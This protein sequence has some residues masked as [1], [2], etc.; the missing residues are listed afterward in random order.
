MTISKA[1]S[2][3]LHLRL[4]IV[5][6]DIQ[7]TNIENHKGGDK[8]MKERTRENVENSGTKLK[9]W[10]FIIFCQEKLLTELFVP[11]N[12]KYLIMKGVLFRFEMAR[13]WMA[14]FRLL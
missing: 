9:F 12:K 4:R 6:V 14:T 11:G 8:E 3:C 13:V 5:S 10:V 2:M 7:M 1:K